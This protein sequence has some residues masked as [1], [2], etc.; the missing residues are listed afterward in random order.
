MSKLNQTQGTSSSG[1]FL[2]EENDILPFKITTT[3]EDEE[4][5]KQ[6]RNKRRSESREGQENP[7]SSSISPIDKSPSQEILTRKTPSQSNETRT[8]PEILGSILGVL[9]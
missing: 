3:L 6:K 2:E 8:I 5:E 7:W 4:E 9:I 1:Q